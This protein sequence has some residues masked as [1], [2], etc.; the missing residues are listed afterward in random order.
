MKVNIEYLNTHSP[1]LINRKELEMESVYTY[2]PVNK[3]KKEYILFTLD[4]KEYVI[5]KRNTSNTYFVGSWTEEAKLASN[6][7]FV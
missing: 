2:N 1:F 7:S 6:Y 4:N 5:P 3:K